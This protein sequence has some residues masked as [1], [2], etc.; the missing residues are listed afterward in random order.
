MG[1]ACFLEGKMKLARITWLA[2][3]CA[4]LAL[5]QSKPEQKPAEEKESKPQSTK[6]AAAS[7]EKEDNG[8]HEGIKVH[9]HWVLQI[10]NRDGSVASRREFDNSLATGPNNG[11]AALSQ[12]L[13]GVVVVRPWFVQFSSGGKAVLGVT[14]AQTSCGYPCSN[15]LTID[16]NSEPGQLVFQGV[17]PLATAATTVDTVSNLVGLCGISVN[18]VTCIGQG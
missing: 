8:N 4:A 6:P 10:R 11:G 7:A 1:Y 2:V 14:T 16:F 17:T 15:F 9:G 12:I 18:P 3:T 13:A 5:G